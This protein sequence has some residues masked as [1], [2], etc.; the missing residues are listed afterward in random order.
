MP[1][2]LRQKITKPNGTREKLR[3]MLMNLSPSVEV[4]ME[5]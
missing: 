1:I 5:R 3:K 4:E 2:F